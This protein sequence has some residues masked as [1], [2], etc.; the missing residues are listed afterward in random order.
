[1][2]HRS[3]RQALLRRPFATASSNAAVRRTFNTHHYAAAMIV[4]SFLGSGGASA[5]SL[6]TYQTLPLFSPKRCVSTNATSTATSSLAD[7]RGV[8]GMGVS[9]AALTTAAAQQRLSGVP[10]PPEPEGTSPG[11]TWYPTELIRIRGRVEGSRIKGSKL[12]FLHLR[13]P[14]N[15]SIQVV[16]AKANTEN[17]VAA[18]S[19]APP[20]SSTPS[21]LLDV[22]RTITPES[23][24]DVWGYLKASPRPVTSVS[25]AHLELHATRLEI[26]TV[27]ETPLPFPLRDVNTK[28]DTRLDHR[29]IDLRTASTGAIARLSSMVNTAFRSFLLAK[30]FV[31]IHTPKMIGT[32]SEGGSSVFKLDYFGKE[33]FLAQSPQLY[34]Q[35]V[36]MGDIP[37]VFEI[38]PVFRAENSLTHRHLTEFVGL[39]VELV[40]HNHYSEVLNVLEGTLVTILQ[41]LERDG[42][43]LRNLALGAVA[44]TSNSG[45]ATA[46]ATM[47]TPI[48]SLL[49]QDIVKALKLGSYEENIASQDTYL[50]YVSSHTSP[51]PVLRMPFDSAVQLL[52]DNG[53]LTSHVDD[54]NTAQEKQLGNLIKQRYG[55][56]V[57]VVDQFPISA[58]PF[59]TMPLPSN[60]LRT[61]SYDMYLRGEE[62]CSGAQRIHDPELLQERMKACGVN[63]ALIQDYVNAF[64][65][66]AWPH[67]GFGL[68]LERIVL[69]YL[70][71]PDVRMVS[72]FPRD[73]KRITP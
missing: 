14:F 52:I 34:K 22:A 12:G 63:V 5:S 10:P 2:L 27:A 57:Y 65:Y 4:D 46:A 21:S 17:S 47:P 45:G 42:A 3:T 11:A 23:V 18:A 19:G 73:P 37:R 25:C 24:V 60:P 71:V 41:T 51:F 35:M 33:G 31:E 49:T 58:R 8:Q 38:G 7:E 1:M 20:Q 16:V 62:I 29:V 55:V 70:G 61:C 68:G 59:Y 30:D 6:T 26:V 67:G 54:F 69:F 15:E 40:I 50:G 56:D 66:G 32:P 39:D 48:Q 13:Q 43:V 9:I 64:R 53:V 72:L 28:L 36:L 44:G